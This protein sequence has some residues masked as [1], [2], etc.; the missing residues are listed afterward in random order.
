MVVFYNRTNV[1]A[2]ICHEEIKESANRCPV[3]GSEKIVDN[4]EAYGLKWN[5]NST[6]SNV[7]SFLALFLTLALLTILG[8]I[9]SLLPEEYQYGG[10][11]E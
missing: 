11:K 3:Y 6:N 9:W 8:I 5:I 10:D 7:R 2:L 4:G 1:F